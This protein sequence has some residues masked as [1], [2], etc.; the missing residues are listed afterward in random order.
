LEDVENKGI[1][2]EMAAKKRKKLQGR[3]AGAERIEPWGQLAV[4][5]GRVVVEAEVVRNRSRW[6]GVREDALVAVVAEESWQY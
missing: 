3:Q 2:A 1:G 6:V 4:A 5:A